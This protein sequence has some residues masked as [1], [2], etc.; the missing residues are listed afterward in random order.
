MIRYSYN[1]MRRHRTPNGIGEIRCQQYLVFQA[2]E[3]LRQAKD[4]EN[5][6]ELC[7]LQMKETPD[8]L[9]PYLFAGFAY[10]Q[11]PGKSQEALVMFKFVADHAGDDPAYT[12]ALPQSQN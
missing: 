2:M 7:Q 3:S 10:L 12:Q 9:T 1:G 5:L 11:M 6:L 8:W 4:W